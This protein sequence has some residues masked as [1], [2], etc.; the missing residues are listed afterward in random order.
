MCAAF[1]VVL[2]V[3][4]GVCSSQPRSLSCSLA[5]LHAHSCTR[6]FTQAVHHSAIPSA[7][8]PPPLGH[9]VLDLVPRQVAG[10]AR[11]RAPGAGAAGRGAHSCAFGVAE[12]PGASVGPDAQVDLAAEKAAPPQQ[13]NFN[14]RSTV[15]LVLG[16]GNQMR[17]D[18]NQNTFRHTARHPQPPLVCIALCGAVPRRQ[19][20]RVL[21]SSART[22]THLAGTL[23]LM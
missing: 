16:C 23:L 18:D 17:C 20:Q 11:A 19:H 4:C 12:R 21:L 1:A 2:I 22:T 9:L 6:Q 15:C 7:T 8:H 10:F 3:T 13:C 5:C 14:K